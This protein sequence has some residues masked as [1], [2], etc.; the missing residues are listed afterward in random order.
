MKDKRSPID[1]T[2]VHIEDDVSNWR[3]NP[4]ILFGM[5]RELLEDTPDSAVEIEDP[6]SRYDD[7]VETT[8][9]WR[10]GKETKVARFIF[11]TAVGVDDF[12][13]KLQGKLSFI[14]D[15]RRPGDDNKLEWTLFESLASVA[16]HIKDS[17]SEIR[18]FTAYRDVD[19]EIKATKK[20]K[21]SE[22][23]NIEFPIDVIS[24]TEPG[25]LH[26]YMLKHLGFED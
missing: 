13:D 25:E 17:K 6:D 21:K 23:K 18:V 26:A 9:T 5:I 2:I 24:K 8:I 7:T 14:L 20:A 22:F 1:F 3:E 15:A 16:P 12:V 19:D 10:I 11:T 4:G